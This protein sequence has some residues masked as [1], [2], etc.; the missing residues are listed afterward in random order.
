M[1][2]FLY[3]IDFLDLVCR[4][5]NEDKN[6]FLFWIEKIIIVFWKNIVDWILDSKILGY[7]FFWLIMSFDEGIDFNSV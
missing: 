2:C 5:K 6:Y 4:K 1:L 3:L 7:E